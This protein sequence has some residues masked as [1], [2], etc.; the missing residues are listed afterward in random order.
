MIS[1]IAYPTEKTKLAFTHLQELLQEQ[2]Q[3]RNNASDGA[4]LCAISPGSCLLLFAD[5]SA[6]NNDT[7]TGFGLA[8]DLKR[9][10]SDLMASATHDERQYTSETRVTKKKKYK[11]NDTRLA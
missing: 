11:E 2:V 7:F 6:I 4:G 1:Y 5:A 8:P 3:R 9:N 10:F